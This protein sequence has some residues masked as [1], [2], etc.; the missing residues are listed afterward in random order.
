[1]GRRD[2]K[3][4]KKKNG[5]PATRAAKSSRVVKGLRRASKARPAEGKLPSEETLPLPGRAAEL[6]AA[7]GY[8]QAPAGE[9]VDLLPDLAADVLGQRGRSIV[10]AGHHVLRGG[11]AVV[12]KATALVPDQRPVAGIDPVTELEQR[13]LALGLP[14]EQVEKVVVEPAPAC[15]RAVPAPPALLHPPRPLHHKYAPPSP[16]PPP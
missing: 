8:R 6:L 9:L 3:P 7:R 4:K 16:Q 15:R 1:M 10:E 13:H 2:N 11:R 14:D 12:K 5:A